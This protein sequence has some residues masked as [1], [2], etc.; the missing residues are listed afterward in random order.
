MATLREMIQQNDQLLQILDGAYKEH[1]QAKEHHEAAM[2]K[3][4]DETRARN[5]V[6]EGFNLLARVVDPNKDFS[7]RE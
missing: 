5:Y 4:A 3:V 2:K 1:V 7:I 6:R